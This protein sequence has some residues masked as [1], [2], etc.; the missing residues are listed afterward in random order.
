MKNEMLASEPLVKVS[1]G[2]LTF[3]RS[4]LLQ[5]YESDGLR[6]A[7][8][9]N[10]LGDTMVREQDPSYPE[11]VSE[12]LN[13]SA[14]HQR[15]EKACSA[16]G[17]SVARLAITKGLLQTD[18][19]QVL[20]KEHA[21]KVVGPADSYITNVEELPIML[22][23]ADCQVAFLFDPVKRVIGASHSGFLGTV[24]ASVA[25]TAWSMQHHFVC[26][27]ED[28]RVAIGPAISGQSFIP[29]E[30]AGHYDID[31]MDVPAEGIIEL[32]DSKKGFDIRL[33]AKQQLRTFAGIPEENI[34]LSSIDTYTRPDLFSYHRM[35]L[36]SGGKKLD[37]RR[38]LAVIA[39]QPGSNN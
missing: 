5:A 1:Q 23:A 15:W 33:V 16:L 17:V 13:E 34:E 9:D 7:W 26:K 35:Y 27:P 2:G 32:P 18:I 37:M 39:L 36:D 14:A 10:S 24:K 31:S 29:A 4:S 38:N 19:V 30:D 25:K 28:I 8:F 21:G 22:R 3:F 20:G 6:H 11:R 12:F